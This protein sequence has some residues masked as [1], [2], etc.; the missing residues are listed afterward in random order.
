M[1]FLLFLLKDLLY[2]I[3]IEMWSNLMGKIYN[4]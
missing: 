2:G 3:I 4:K 1:F